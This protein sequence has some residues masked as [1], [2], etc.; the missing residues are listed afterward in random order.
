[1]KTRK[2]ALGAYSSVARATASLCCFGLLT[3]LF[4]DTHGVARAAT[5][6]SPP[7]GPL[8]GV[9]PEQQG[10]TTLPG[11]HFNF[12]L[13]PGESI[14]DGIV[15]ENFSNHSLRFHVYGADLITAT[16][17][18]LAPVQPTATMHQ[19]GAWIVVSSPMLTVPAHGRLTDTFALTVPAAIAPGQHL[20]AVVAAAIV[21]VTPQGS[22]IEA[23]TALI[24]VVSVPGT[25]NALARLSP[26]VG[27]GTDGARGFGITLLNVG[28]VL[29]TYSGSV[30]VDDG[31]GHDV[32]ILPLAPT[33][34]YVVP[35]GATPL[36]AVWAGRAPASGTYRAQ[37]TVT[38]LANGTPVR[39]LKSQVLVMRFASG[40][41]ILMLIL[42]VA[43]VILGL[44]TIVLI[45][46]SF[47]RRGERQQRRPDAW[48]PSGARLRG[49][50]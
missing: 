42:L 24:T 38:I 17:G 22:P 41:P 47:K 5:T 36:A 28:N 16:G 4:V 15:V 18:G 20:G 40:P 9:H 8:F 43:G 39:T 33:N 46:R 27:S 29:L 31:V 19:A 45:A 1:M 7:S 49:L 21:G 30:S 13:V 26:L 3:I 37:A 50:R 12:A 44:G 48:T 32:A 25:A 34:A 11:G 2:R 23:R 10:S 6:A 35:G 14:T